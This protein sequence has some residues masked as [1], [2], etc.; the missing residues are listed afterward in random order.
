MA[1]LNKRTPYEEELLQ[2]LMD[3]FHQACGECV[4]RDAKGAFKFRYQNAGLSA[5]EDAEDM[6]IEAGMIT[7]KQCGRRLTRR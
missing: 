6:L 7:E 1:H 5:Y 4:G 3:C 2:A